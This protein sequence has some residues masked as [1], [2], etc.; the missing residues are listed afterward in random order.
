MFREFRRFREADLI[1]A[2]HAIP[3]R[4]LRVA[5]LPMLK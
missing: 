5:G 4:G 3:G 2:E 1:Y